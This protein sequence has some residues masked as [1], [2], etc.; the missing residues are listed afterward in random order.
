MSKPSYNLRTFESLLEIMKTLRSPGGCPW[1]IEQTPKTLLPYLIEESAELVEAVEEGDDTEYCEELGDVLLQVVFHAQIAAEENRFDISDVLQAVNGKMIS[2]HPHVFGDSEA[3]TSEQVLV[4]WEKIKAGEKGK[5]KRR[6]LLDGVP[7]TFPAL[8]E[9]AKLQ[10]KAAK[11]GFD[12]PDTEG[13]MEK[14]VEE[15]RELQQA[16]DQKDHDAAEAELGDLLFSVVNLAR[17]LQLDPELALRR[18]NRKF[19]TRF[20]AVEQAAASANQNLEDC[21]L[22]ELDLLWEQAKEQLKG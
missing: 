11:A 2:R 1:D 15:A 21:T 13:P 19:R 12:W 22:E 5:E 20:A 10:K 8:A 16:V 3:E 17:K 6:S 9:G 4:Q 18:T 14:I 7:K